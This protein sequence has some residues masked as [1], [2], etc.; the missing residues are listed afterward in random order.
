MSPVKETARVKIEAMTFGRNAITRLDGKVVMVAGAAP[1]DLLEIEISAEL[2]NYALARVV[3]LVQGGDERRQPPCEY[4]NDCGGCDWQHL[5]YEAQ[6]RHKAELLAAEFRR[7]LAIE[8]DPSSLVEP[9][10]AELGYRSRVRLKTARGAVGFSRSRSNSIVAIDSCP[11]AAVTI[12]NAASLARALGPIC[13]EIEV[14]AG[15]GGEVLV[16]ELAKAPTAFTVAQARRTVQNGTVGVVLRGDGVRHV[17][18]NARIAFEAE[19]GCMIEADADL[20]SQVNRQ[21]NLKLVGAVMGLARLSP[22][23]RVLDLF[24]GTGNFSLP[25][26]QRGAHVTGADENSLAIEAARANAARMDL[27]GAQFMAMRAA[28]AVRFLSGAG[29]HPDLIILD[30]PRIGAADLIE[31]LVRLG[32]RQV[33]YVS[34]DPITLVRDLRLLT[35]NGYRIEYA[36]AFDFF[37]NTHHLEIIASALL[38]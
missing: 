34:C 20:F 19:P 37:P 1:G 2:P 5:R 13:R 6:I 9:A 23:T 10:P 4:A 21:Q 24:C 17:V 32:G 15:T 31:P 33:I 12:V 3:R 35:Q 38:T 36:R 25:A 29:Y 14:A 16:A 22:G 28:E 27:R 11:V 8:L 26:A 18:G 7:G 30:P